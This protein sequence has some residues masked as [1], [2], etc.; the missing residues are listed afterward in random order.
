MGVAAGPQAVSRGAFPQKASQQLRSLW[1]QAA[2][3]FGDRRRNDE[4][5]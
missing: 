4:Y 5:D 3:D 1:R 2:E